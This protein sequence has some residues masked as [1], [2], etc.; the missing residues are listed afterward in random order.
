MFVWDFK[1]IIIWLFAFVTTSFFWWVQWKPTNSSGH[2]NRWFYSYW[3]M[4]F[5]FIYL[6]AGCCRLLLGLREGRYSQKIRTSPQVYGWRHVQN[7]LVKYMTRMPSIWSPLINPRKEPAQSTHI[8][9]CVR[10][11]RYCWFDNSAYFFGFCCG[12]GSSVQQRWKQSEQQP[13]LFWSKLASL[14]LPFLFHFPRWSLVSTHS[15]KKQPMA[16]F[17]SSGSARRIHVCFVGTYL[18]NIKWN[19]IN[20]CIVAKLWVPIVEIRRNSLFSLPISV[21]KSIY[22]HLCPL[23]CSLAN[24]LARLC[25]F[26]FKRKRR[27]KIECFK[28]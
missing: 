17:W 14:R 16:A 28:Q 5:H 24:K 22:F 18:K 7:L 15:I 11:V 23:S 3:T 19:E 6:G 1:N 21:S 13:M 26:L 8:P 9:E 12:S 25:P 4:P 20:K 2:R 27:I 10:E